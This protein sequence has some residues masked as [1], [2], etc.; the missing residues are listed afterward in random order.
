MGTL[1]DQPPRMERLKEDSII[2]LGISIQNIA[3]ELDITFGEATDLYLA[4]AKI[5][6]YDTKDE[7]MAG[8]GELVRE[9]VD[10]CKERNEM[11]GC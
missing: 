5:A 9:L 3:G 10:V 8:F 4:A 6:D 2:A 7:Q 11:Q 1:F